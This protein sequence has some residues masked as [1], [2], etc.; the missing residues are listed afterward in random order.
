MKRLTFGAFAFAA[1][2]A[3][4]V[5]AHATETVLFT[6]GT[7]VVKRVTNPG[8]SFCG[9]SSAQYPSSGLVTNPQ[10]L[11]FPLSSGIAG[12][13]FVKMPILPTPVPRAVS[14]QERAI[15]SLFIEG[16][17]LAQL[18]QGNTVDYA[19]TGQPQVRLNGAGLKTAMDNAQAKC[20]APA[21]AAAPAPAPAPNSAM[22]QA[23]LDAIM[24]QTQ[25]TAD[26][27]RAAEMNASGVPPSS[28]KP[29]PPVTPAPATPTPPAKE[30]PAI[31][32]ASPPPSPSPV[33]PG[34]PPAGSV[35]ANLATTNPNNLSPAAL[36]LLAKQAAQQ[37]AANTIVNT[38][39]PGIVVKRMQAMQ[40]TNA[41][42]TQICQ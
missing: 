23:Q 4:A 6:S 1:V 21:S 26:K 12:P 28:S 17:E 30:G 34:A 14:A 8:M 19:I 11:V 20:A 3:L 24:A 41:Q 10:R 40:M 2:F 39:C 42:I 27:I 9:V 29:V 25:A 22:T 15:N 16:V 36:D 7:W 5:P 35:G 31:K 38:Q 37:Q 32:P 18:V 13:V 33:T